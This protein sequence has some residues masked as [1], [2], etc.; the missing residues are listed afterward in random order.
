MNDLQF[1]ISYRP[2]YRSTEIY[3]SGRDGEGNRIQAVSIAWNR[4]EI[5]TQVDPLLRLDGKDE[6]QI[7]QNLM[8]ELWNIGIRPAEIGTPG[9]LAA[10]QGHLADMRALVAKAMDVKLKGVT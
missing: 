2:E 9:H 6:K 10:T 3:L 1:S 8:D 4:P 7:L 5:G